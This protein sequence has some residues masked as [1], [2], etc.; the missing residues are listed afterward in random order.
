V[1]FVGLVPQ[2]IGLSDP[3]EEPRLKAV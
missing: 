1:E 2:R 3:G